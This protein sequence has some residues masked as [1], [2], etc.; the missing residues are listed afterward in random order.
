MATDTKDLIFKTTREMRFKDVCKAP[1]PVGTKCALR[2]NQSNIVSITP[3]WGECI[4]IDTLRCVS[5]RLHVTKLPSYF[6]AFER[7]DMDTLEEWM[8][9]GGCESVMGEW[10]EPDGHDCYGSPSWLLAYG[11][12]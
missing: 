6:D 9:D 12:I 1:I 7:P 2:F 3:L 10:V 8:S 5:L 4:N 11:M